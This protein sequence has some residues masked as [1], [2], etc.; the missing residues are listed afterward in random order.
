MTGPPE[1]GRAK[2]TSWTHNQGEVVRTEREVRVRIEKGGNAAECEWPGG[3]GRGGKCE[4]KRR[5]RR[6]RRRRADA[7][8]TAFAAL[9]V[10]AAAAALQIATGFSSAD[11]GFDVQVQ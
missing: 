1:K 8:A 9:A 6:R 7:A 5:R 2:R 3:W 10:L 11:L 4:Q